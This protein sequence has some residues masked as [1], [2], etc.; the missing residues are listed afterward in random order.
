MITVWVYCYVTLTLSPAVFILLVLFFHRNSSCP[1]H[2]TRWVKSQKW[3]IMRRR[4]SVAILAF[5][6]SAPTS[7]YL[8]N[9]LQRHTS[10]ASVLSFGRLMAVLWEKVCSVCH[11][12]MLNWRLLWAFQFYVFQ[13]HQTSDRFTLFI[14]WYDDNVICVKGQ[15][16]VAVVNV[17]VILLAPLLW[18]S[19][20]GRGR[21]P[22]NRSRRSVM[23][24]TALS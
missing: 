12:G 8:K 19:S 16:A 14:M 7:I 5:L 6:S 15:L 22:Q 10:D 23:V 20:S 1:S 9:L 4:D 3:P 13:F 21:G 24:F 11:V 18:Q 17:C 2:H